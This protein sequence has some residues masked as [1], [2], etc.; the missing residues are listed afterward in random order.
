MSIGLICIG[1]TLYDLAA[2]LFPLFP[3]PKPRKAKVSS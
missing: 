1:L 2:R 3:D